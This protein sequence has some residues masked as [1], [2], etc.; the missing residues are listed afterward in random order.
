LIIT[1]TLYIN[2]HYTKYK[3]FFVIVEKTYKQNCTPQIRNLKN[4][5]L[6]EQCI[7]IYV[8]NTKKLCLYLKCYLFYLIH[9]REKYTTKYDEKD[10]MRYWYVTMTRLNAILFHKKYM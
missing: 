4:I 7:N 3:D 10:K 5:Y 6:W 8:V 2:Q 1:S 9:V